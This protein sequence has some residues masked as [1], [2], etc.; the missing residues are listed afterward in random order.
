V[1]AGRPHYRAERLLDRAAPLTVS[2]GRYET[3]GRCRGCGEPIRAL[4]AEQP[5]KLARGVIAG[6]F[7]GGRGGLMCDRCLGAA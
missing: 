5:G 3:F 7:S 1:T 2:E 4:S 6:L